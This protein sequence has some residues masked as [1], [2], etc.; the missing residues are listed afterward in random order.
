MVVQTNARR[1]GSVFP[2]LAGKVALVT[3]VTD[4]YGAAVCRL[5]AARGARI[6]V[7]G[8]DQAA[9][10]ITAEAI[11]NAGGYVT[12]IVMDGSDTAARE[13]ICEQ[14]EQLMGPVDVV[15]DLTEDAAVALT[16]MLR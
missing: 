4:A 11:W 13:R 2:D 7:A 15:V 6:A 1:M 9:I 16:A 5:L 8:P 10:D 12:G 3:G 14:V